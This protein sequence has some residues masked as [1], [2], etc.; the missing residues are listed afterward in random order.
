MRFWVIVW[1]AVIAVVGT[2]SLVNWRALLTPV[3]LDFVI[4]QV[5]A[6]LGVTMLGA[7][8]ILTL[9]FL[10]FLV[11]LE[12][13]ALLRIGPAGGRAEA[14]ELSDVNARLGHVEQVLK[15][16]VTRAIDAL[17]AQVD[18]LERHVNGT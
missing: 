14:R 11:W 17:T 3:A 1:I 15:E 5:T 6:P 4:A 12:T 16:E 10:F 2:F 9:L 18:R 8:V 7:M 13:K